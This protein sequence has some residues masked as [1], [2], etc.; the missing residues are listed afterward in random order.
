[1]T[2]EKSVAN[3]KGEKKLLFLK[4]VLESRIAVAM[5]VTLAAIAE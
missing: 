2:I 3:F 4:T 1:M 5:T